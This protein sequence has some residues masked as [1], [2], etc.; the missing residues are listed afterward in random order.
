M[1][2]DD[3]ASVDAISDAETVFP[4]PM[5]VPAPQP[6]PPQPAPGSIPISSRL[7]NVRARPLLPENMQAR[8]RQPR[9]PV[10]PV[11]VPAGEPR[12]AHTMRV[13]GTYTI[14]YYG[15][16]TPDGRERT[17][18]VR[19]TRFDR[20]LVVMGNEPR[21]LLFSRIGRVTPVVGALGP[22]TRAMS[23]RSRMFA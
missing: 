9:A 22:T 5:P 20:F 19:A 15:V 18:F 12:E 6:A 16:E 13:G 8:P 3:I 21:T 2:T 17:V 23:S 10:Q 7:R 11:E 14:W 1:S 4:P